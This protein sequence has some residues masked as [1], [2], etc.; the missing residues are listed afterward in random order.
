MT[1]SHVTSHLQSARYNVCFVKKDSFPTVQVGFIFYFGNLLPDSIAGYTYIYTLVKPDSGPPFT[2]LSRNPAS[3]FLLELEKLSPG[4][5]TRK[6]DNGSALI[7][8]I[9]IIIINN[10]NN[11]N[12]INNLCSSNE[13]S[14][15][16][17]AG[18]MCE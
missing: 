11:N 2:I 15:N 6:V 18:V 12:N 9:I 3:H 7:I 10:N 4:Q 14:Y 17:S 5:A 13:W 1:R 8:I 16:F